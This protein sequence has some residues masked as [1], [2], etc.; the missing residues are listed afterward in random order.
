MR[1][2]IVLAAVFLFTLFIGFSCSGGNATKEAVQRPFRIGLLPHE[3]KELMLKRYTPLMDHISK[4]LGRQ[5]E[6]RIPETYDELLNLSTRGEIDLAF[7]GGFTFV[8]SNLQSGTEPLVMRDVDTR[9]TSFFLVRADDPA[10]SLSDLRGRSLSFGS[11]LSTSGHL[12]PRHFLKEKMINP[13][14]F[15]REIRYSGAHDK[16][17]YWVRD[18]KADVGVAN[19]AIIRSM[20]KD[21]RLK[22]SEVRVLWETPPYPDY[23]WTLCSGTDEKLQA[24]LLDAFLELSPTNPEHAEILRAMNAGGFLPAGTDDFR[25][26]FEVVEELKLIKNGKNQ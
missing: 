23:V 1:E 16:T 17:A 15:F 6:I 24:Q 11:E 3:N 2:R 18:R 4:K 25:K 7:L 14:E 19:S 26:L 5:C 20:Y 13:E 21:G 10:Q 22:N 8:K 9:F 12:M